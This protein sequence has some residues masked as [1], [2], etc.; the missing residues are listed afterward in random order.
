MIFFRLITFFLQKVHLNV[1]TYCLFVYLCEMNDDIF[2]TIATEA[3]FSFTEK[4]SRFLAFAYPVKD[5]DE[6]NERVKECR[7]K[8]Y[9]A[10]HVCYAYVLSPDGSIFRANDDQEPSG[11]A[12]KPILGQI[13]SRELTNTL[14]MVVRYFG[15]V[16][17]G[18]SGLT[19]AYK[20]A[21]AGALDE[22]KIM[23]CTVDDK[24]TCTFPYIQLNDVMRAVKELKPT[25]EEQKFDTECL[26][27]LRLRRSQMALL[28][29]KLEKIESLK[30]ETVTA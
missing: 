2:H 28:R 22:A 10:R 3:T 7:K 21:A 8:Y 23:E 9:D 1:P 19:A 13:N 12:G 15:G 18:T 27:T 29:N 6:V 26:I 16:K 30:I 17:L 4:R 24:V 14:V 5:L 11:T 20:E 25:V